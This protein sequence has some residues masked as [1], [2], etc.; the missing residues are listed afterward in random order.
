MMAAQ[1]LAPALACGCTCILKPA[2][3]TPLT[4]CYLGNLIKEA[5]FP[6]GVV[7]IVPGYGHTAGAAISEHM[8]IDKVAFTGSTQ[9]GQMIS[10]AAA[11]SNL[12][13]VTLELGGKSPV[14]IFDDC[15]LDKAVE[16]AY[17]GVFINSGQV[18]A[19]GTRVFVQD[20]VY[21]EFILKCV[22]RAK[23]RT[24]G[25]PFEVQNEQGPQ[26]SKKQF[27]SV[28]KYIKLGKDEGAK[29]MTGGNKC[30][31]KGY[32]IEPTVFADVKDNMTIAKEE[33]FGPV[34]SILKF[35]SVDEV[36]ER[37]NATSYGLAAAVFSNDFDRLM[38]VSSAVRAGIV[39]G[40][41]LLHMS[42]HTPFGGYKM[43]GQGRELGEYGLQAYTEVKTVVTAISQ[44]N[45]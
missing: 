45:S 34:Q 8:D 21:D 43:S 16:A 20:T 35:S 41:C 23:K 36:V 4:A 6:P 14:I 19:A 31:D 22:E 1:K 30:G 40:N 5:G 11:G 26:V 28:M 37:A 33:I 12:K 18:C 17:Q 29:L 42:A 32:F 25:N 9:V 39:W 13:R 2:E 27:D 24:V 15:D 38:T 7:N 3:Q 10:K 44:K